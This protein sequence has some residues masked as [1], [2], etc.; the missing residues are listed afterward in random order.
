M[1]H[2]RPDLQGAGPLAFSIQE[3]IGNLL[4]FGENKAFF[5]KK[6]VFLKSLQFEA[7]GCGNSV[8]GGKFSDLSLRKIN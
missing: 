3:K 7:W 1:F 8:N 4:Y 6:R 2:E 5:T